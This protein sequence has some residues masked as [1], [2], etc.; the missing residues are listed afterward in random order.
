MSSKKPENPSRSP[1]STLD[2]FG[3]NSLHFGT[4]YEKIWEP[5]LNFPRKVRSKGPICDNF[6][7][8]AL[9]IVEYK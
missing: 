7:A 3:L 4:G 8:E 5:R 2:D 1:Q 6:T 9:Q